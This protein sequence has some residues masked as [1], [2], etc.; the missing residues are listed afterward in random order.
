MILYGIV[1]SIHP[2]QQKLLCNVREGNNSADFG[3]G[4]CWEMKVRLGIIIKQ[5]KR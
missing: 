3:R 5:Y 2:P 1:L 4:H